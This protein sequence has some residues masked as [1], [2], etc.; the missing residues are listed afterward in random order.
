M[1]IGA[2]T[3]YIEADQPNKDET[4]LGR[5][6]VTTFKG[7]H[8][9]TR[10]IC[11]YNPCY[12]KNP[13]S[14]TTYKQHRWFFITQRKDLT[15]P[16]TKIKEDLI[17]LLYQWRLIVCLDANED[18]YKKSLG[19]ALTDMDGLAMK[20]V[21][22][23]F[24]GTP[25]GTKFFRGSKPIDGIW[26]TTNIM[27]CNA[28]V[29]LAGYGIGDH[30][31]FVI[32]FAAR[33]IVESR[34]PLVIRAASRWLNTKLP[35]VAAEYAR[36]LET[37]II[38]HKLIKRVNLAHDRSSSTRLLTCHLNRLNRE[39]GNYMRFAEKRCRK[40]KSGR[41]LFSLESSLWICWTQVYQS[42]LKYQAGRIRNKGNLN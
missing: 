17:A 9:Q 8:G 42:L 1:I 36:L 32:N 37:K 6:A 41:I 24:T 5:W 27:V 2:L 15:C 4:G 21:V 19:R 30:R 29:M 33:N 40:I 38:R 14:S 39:L 34:P 35:G 26:A 7:N 22:G 20:E 16:R 23:D 28:S 12:N 10:V 18:I 31:L 25:L 13:D 3:E 11:G